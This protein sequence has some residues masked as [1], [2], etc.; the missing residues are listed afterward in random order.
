MSGGSL[1]GLRRSSRRLPARR[2]GGPSS[3]R[4]VARVAVGILLEIVLV[5]VL[6]LP[7]RTRRLD[8]DHHRSRRPRR[9]R[10]C[11]SATALLVVEVVD[12][13]AIARPEVVPLRFS[14]VGSWIRRTRAGRGRTSAQGRRRSRSTPHVAVIVIGGVRD[15]PARVA[16]PRLQDAWPPTDEILHPLGIR[17]R[18]SPSRPDHPPGPLQAKA[19][20]SPEALRPSRRAHGRGKSAVA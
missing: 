10:S 16:D 11:P 17:P 1:S 13:R 7:E 15:V 8:L 14:V 19:S 9:R 4:E 12:R 18:G 6:G 2:E 5:L 3:P 20:R